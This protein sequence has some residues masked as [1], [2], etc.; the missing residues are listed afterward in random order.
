VK[1]YCEGKMKK[2]PKGIEKETEIK[3]F[4]SS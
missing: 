2:N 3:I 1:K 4:K